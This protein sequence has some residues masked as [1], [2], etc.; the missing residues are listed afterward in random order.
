MIDLRTLY[1]LAAIVSIWCVRLRPTIP[2]DIPVENRN[3]SDCFTASYPVTITFRTED[4]EVS[5]WQALGD[6]KIF[7][8][9]YDQVVTDM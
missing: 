2:R 7:Y 5:L 8:L 9:M 6:C 4:G 3:G 1:V